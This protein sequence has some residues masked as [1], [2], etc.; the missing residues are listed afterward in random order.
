M[1]EYIWC[2]EAPNKYHPCIY[3]EHRGRKR[4]FSPAPLN[5][6]S[7][8]IDSRVPDGTFQVVENHSLLSNYFG[9]IYRALF[10]KSN[11]RNI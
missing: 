8:A 9:T 11:I 5:Q 7:A 3:S 2:Q 6:L 4:G 1:I 10:N